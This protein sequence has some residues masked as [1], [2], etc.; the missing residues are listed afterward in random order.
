MQAA[1][2]Q[3][4]GA[5]R[6]RPWAWHGGQSPLHSNPGVGVDSPLSIRDSP[7]RA[8]CQHL[9]GACLL[10]TAASDTGQSCCPPA[11]SVTWFYAS[12]FL[13][14]WIFCNFTCKPLATK[15]IV[16]YSEL[17]A[18]PS[19]QGRH[20]KKEKKISKICG[21]SCSI[22]HMT[23][24]GEEVAH[25]FITLPGCQGWARQ[26]RNSKHCVKQGF[27]KIKYTKH[28]ALYWFVILTSGCFHKVIADAHS[29]CLQRKQSK[30]L[31]CLTASAS[32]KRLGHF[33]RIS[34]Y[35]WCWLC[36]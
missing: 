25:S 9:S 33:K 16:I 34:N 17:L 26:L 13:L 8:G 6:V 28:I 18:T 21:V 20:H 29:C 5:A 1:P 4:R 22:C 36:I 24:A 11:D 7:G 3:K 10:G 14:I 19:N 12:F 31:S 27:I 2:G 35:L 15:W 30:S 32:K 23:P